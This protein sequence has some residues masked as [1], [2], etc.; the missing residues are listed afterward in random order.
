MEFS[1]PGENDP[2][3]Q[4]V[5]KW[6]EAHPSPTG[7]ELAEAGLVAPH[8]PKP[9]GR[10]ADPI[11]Q[12]VIEEELRKAKVTRPSNTIGIGWAGPT[13]LHAGTKEQ[14]ERYLMP[15][16]SAKEIWCQLF[17]EP[18]SGSDLASLST[19]AYID[20]DN[21]V[22]NGQKIWTSFGHVAKFGILLVRTNPEVPK[23]QGISYLICPMDSPGITVR[24]I[25]DM[26]GMHTFNEVFFDDVHIPVENLVGELNRGWELAKV[27]LANERVSLSTGGVLWGNGPVA[28]DLIDLVKLTGGTQD[29]L[30]RQEL[31]KVY[32]EGE[33]L[34]WL[35]LRL[36]SAAVS[37]QEPGPES[38]VRKALGDEHGQNL[39]RVAKSMAG[40]SGMVD[41]GSFPGNLSPFQNAIGYWNIGFIFS[42]A[43]TVGGGTSEI[44]RNII[45]EK[46]LG[47]P[48]EADFDAVK[49]WNERAGG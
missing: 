13:I 7:E 10:E 44:Q 27:T 49:A 34:R 8:W 42:A 28:K 38:S 35:S 43:L 31:A 48:K 15:I 3:R 46:T 21:F 36:I 25:V 19:R 2:I 18:G 9:F 37:G 16:L 4:E 47:L 33:I 12:L 1:L 5:R 32:T 23:H 26:T 24:P 29:P 11:S 39:M 20:G 45:A 17:S 22:V 41:V 14:K 6:L 40:A 30:V